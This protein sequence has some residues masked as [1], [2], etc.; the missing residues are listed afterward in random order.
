LRSNDLVGEPYTEDDFWQ[1]RFPRARGNAAAWDARE[2][3]LSQPPTASRRVIR[4]DFSATNFRGDIPTRAVEPRDD[5]AG[6]GLAHARKDDR[7]RPSLRLVLNRSMA[8]A[9]ANVNRAFMC[10]SEG[11]ALLR[12][13]LPQQLFV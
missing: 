12:L 9:A 2:S 1:W 3:G 5:A 10:R 7:D 4:G 6:D 11:C 8:M 13:E